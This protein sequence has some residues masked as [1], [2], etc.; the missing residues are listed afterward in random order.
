LE[1]VAGAPLRFSFPNGEAEP[2]DGE[3]LTF[4]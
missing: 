4:G 1:R 3:M 2:S